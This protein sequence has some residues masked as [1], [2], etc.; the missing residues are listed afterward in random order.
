[1]ELPIADWVQF[2]AAHSAMMDFSSEAPGLYQ[3]NLERQEKLRQFLVKAREMR[4]HEKLMEDYET[5]NQNFLLL[6]DGR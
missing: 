3:P 6:A 2:Q 4:P 1:M 5:G